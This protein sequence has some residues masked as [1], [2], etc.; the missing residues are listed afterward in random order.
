[1]CAILAATKEMA[2]TS[3][4]TLL[5]VFLMWI[6]ERFDLLPNSKYSLEMLLSSPN[7]VKLSNVPGRTLG[8]NV[9]GVRHKQE[10]KLR[11]F[12]SSLSDRFRA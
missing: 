1:M 11:N 6:P 12:A 2:N 5:K 7:R 4:G 3:A 10:T 8:Q 9:L